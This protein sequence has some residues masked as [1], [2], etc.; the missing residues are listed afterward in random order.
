MAAP[1]SLRTTILADAHKT[2][3]GAQRRLYGMRQAMFFDQVARTS[4]A[5][6]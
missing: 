5:R 4:R 2:V 6:F 3:L 1:T